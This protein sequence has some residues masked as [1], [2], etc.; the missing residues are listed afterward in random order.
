M[1]ICKNRR[2]LLFFI[3]ILIT[4][5]LCITASADESS[6]DVL[7]GDS[8]PLVTLSYVDKVIKELKE[9]ILRQSGGN[10]IVS[11]SSA[12]AD[13]S[14][15]SGK[16]LLLGVDCELIYRGGGAVIITTST[17][18]GDGVTDMSMGA[19]LFSGK[20]LEYGHVYY[21][22][23]SDAKKYLLIT[24]EKAYFTIRG[25]YEIG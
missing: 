4:A 11:G 21:S 25:S 8:D 2:L 23:N 16:M 22:S 19:E 13:I 10:T 3:V 1:N 7:S 5:T 17:Q 12:Y 15:E 14:I 18:K 20:S 6:D 9:E 24:G